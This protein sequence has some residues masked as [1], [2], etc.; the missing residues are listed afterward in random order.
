MSQAA[1]GP[2]EAD[3]YPPPRHLL[4]DLGLFTE[5]RD[6]ALWTGLVPTPALTGDGGRLHA[7]VLA[8]L[9]DVAGGGLA[10]ES[11]APDWI[12]TQDLSLHCYDLPARGEVT[13]HPALVRHS[14]TTVIV[15]ASLRDAATEIGRATMTFRVLPSRGG[16]QTYDRD[17]PDDR[18]EFALPDSGLEGT[19]AD[20]LGL[21]RVEGSVWQHALGPYLGNSLGA[22]QGG[23]VAILADLVAQGAAEAALGGSVRIDDL[24]LQYLSLVKVGPVR[25]HAEV[26]HHDA[27]GAR[28]R[29][30]IRDGGADDRLCTLVH[31]RASA[32]RD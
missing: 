28:L 15:E 26:L 31:A 21:E 7:G 22:M 16:A 18:F 6:G 17:R 30:E 27:G 29:V 11:A 25:A 13:A 2:P 8:T 9:V 10:L 19:L 3:A 12:A 4:R 14:A 1:P 5:R 24:A 20:A 23:A 32:L